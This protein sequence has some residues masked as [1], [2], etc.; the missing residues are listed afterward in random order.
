MAFR[1]PDELP[2]GDPALLPRDAVIAIDGPAGSGKSTT[3][4]ALADRFGLLY[5]DTGAMYR[6]L[7]CVVLEAGIDPGDEER[8][9]ALL[10]A[11]RLDLAPSRG[12]TT[13]VWD[14]RDVSRAIRTPAVE[15]AVSRVSSHAGVRTR[16]VERQ[17]ALGRR[18]GVVMEGRDIGSVVFPLATAKIHLSASPE[19][20]AERR[21]LQFNER[22][23]HVDR[24]ALVHELTDRDRQDSERAVSPL[25]V[26]PDAIVVDSSALTLDQQN[27]LCARACLVN[28]TLDRTVDRDPFAA[29]RRLPDVYRLAY[30]G[31]GALARFWGLREFG[32]A[33]LAAPAGCILAV[34][35][36]SVWDP[37]LVAATFRRSPVHALAKAE[38]FRPDWL[39]GRFFRWIDAIPI[40]RKGYDRAAF[41]AA[42]EGLA[43]GHSLLIFPEGTRQAIGHPGLVRSGL[44]ILVQETRAP[45]V[46]IF[47]RGAYGR[48]AG[49]SAD[50][51]LEVWYGPLLRWHAVDDLLERLDRREV[52][53]RIGALCR[54]A[55]CELQ[56]RSHLANPSTEFEKQLGEKQLRQFSRRQARLFGR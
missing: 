17:Q 38:L 27:E 29:R 39:G 5:I 15:A 34:N 37:P 23:L 36:T 49:G 9:V 20:R 54:A 56:A 14:G 21:F 28:P 10:D 25:Q 35:H 16:M 43:A 30:A 24:Q 42:A 41:G 12:E 1:H 18:G 55:W 2:P 52:S 46:P 7:T 22:G 13:V 51:P 48:R 31:M 40:H 53:E 6:A 4:R 33:G 11:A 47:L 3:A 26:S 32:N 45:V 8:L 50:S 19:A 44:G